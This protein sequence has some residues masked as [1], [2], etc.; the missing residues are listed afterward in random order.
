[1]R[2]RLQKQ[3]PTIQHG[4]P[5]KSHDSHTMPRS[6]INVNVIVLHY[7]TKWLLTNRSGRTIF[8]WKRTI[9][10]VSLLLAVSLPPNMLRKSSMRSDRWPMTCCTTGRNNSCISQ[11][12]ELRLKHRRI[13]H[14]I[15]TYRNI[16][17]S[18]DNNII[19][20][21]TILCKTLNLNRLNRLN[22]KTN[23]KHQFHE[24]CD[25]QSL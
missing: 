18:L 24:T 10:S 8:I 3:Q 1:M 16:K 4:V 17:Y 19:K 20:E 13:A 6:R 25:R 21:K 9:M 15:P 7:P 2:Q 11:R 5:W 14:K 23:K 22:I 12:N